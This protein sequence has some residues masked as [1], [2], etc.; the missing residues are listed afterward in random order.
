M[1]RV[2][3]LGACSYAASLPYGLAMCGGN[4]NPD[5]KPRVQLKRAILVIRHGD[6]SPITS[7]V[8]ESTLRATPALVEAWKKKLPAGD[9]LQKG[10]R[11]FP[12]EPA[13]VEVLDK[14]E[15]P[16][17][18]LTKVGVE[19]HRNL[20]SWLR[21][22]LVPELLDESFKAESIRVVSTRISRTLQSA[23]GVLQGLY[24]N[25]WETTSPKLKKKIQVQENP[26]RDE[27][28]Y[29]PPRSG[30]YKCHRISQLWKEICETPLLET[31]S[32]RQ[33]ERDLLARDP[34]LRGGEI[35][36]GTWMGL[37]EAL[38]CSKLHGVAMDD[39]EFWTAERLELVSAIGTRVANRAYANRDYLALSIGRLMNV[40]ISDIEEAFCGPAE[41]FVLYSG[42]DS[43]IMPLTRALQVEPANGKWSPYASNILIEIGSRERERER[44]DVVRITLNGRCV[45]P[46][47]MIQDDDDDDDDDDDGWVQW[48]RMKRIMQEWDT[49]KPEFREICRVK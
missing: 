45:I 15:F 47:S 23:R 2:L 26:Q 13:G 14:G 41:K 39:D 8:G 4:A 20:G 43:T 1:R 6:R 46:R 11:L 18:Q 36:R 21:R 31:E 16:W 30:E 32:E 42:H 25:V 49:S 34:G 29:G 44:D 27:F 40:L 12:Q 38:L 3:A 10:R 5:T 9:F 37:R 24:P 33:L 35:G 7:V 28:L 19:Q 17:G 22:R 48:H